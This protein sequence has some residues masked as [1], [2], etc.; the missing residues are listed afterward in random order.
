MV[1]FVNPSI[2]T[3]VFPIFLTS[4]RTL[5]H[6]PSKNPLPIDTRNNEEYEDVIFILVDGFGW[7][8]FQK[9]VDHY[10]FLKRFVSEGIVSKIT[11]QFPSTTAAHV[12]TLN[13]GLHVGE[14][15]VYEWFQYEPVLD[16]VIC[17]L[18]FS[19]AGD[20]EQGTLKY[21]SISPGD[22]FPYR[23]FYEELSSSNVESYIFTHEDIVESLYSNYFTKGA[24]RIGY[25]DVARGLTKLAELV[26]TPSSKKRYFYFY[27][28][29]I[30]S[31]GH[32]QGCLSEEFKEAVDG[33]FIAL[34]ECIY[35]MRPPRKTACIVTADHGMIDVDPKSTIYLN[36]EL[37]SIKKHIKKNKKRELSFLRGH[38]GTSFSMFMIDEV[39]QTKKLLDDFLQDRA[40]VIPTQ[41][42][43]RDNFFGPTISQAFLKRV[44]NLVIL[45]YN[46]ESVWWH[47]KPKFSRISLLS[48]GG[49]P[50]KKWNRFFYLWM[51]PKSHLLI[52]KPNIF[53][54]VVYKL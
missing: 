6:L 16:Q 13:T 52:L 24:T 46:H 27:L 50:D 10:P 42:L 29:D 20:K 45:P 7:R 48:T 5:F 30:D 3:I 39:I 51:L 19:Y 22:L 12:T 25:E 49:F 28:S 2:K 4:I 41:D 31:M 14:S 40:L 34:E 47:D 44:G 36:E 18:L 8:F 11:S 43:I 54:M 9:Y 33:N 38:A 53:K 26:K 32:R 17:P 35:D 23:T 37:P 21:N 15:G 1:F